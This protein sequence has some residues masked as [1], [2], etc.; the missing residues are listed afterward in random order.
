MYILLY[1]N[2]TVTVNQKSII[3]TQKRE[4]NLNITLKTVI[5]PQETRT[6]EEQ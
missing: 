4:R 6:K 2:L 1:I 5:K 3:D